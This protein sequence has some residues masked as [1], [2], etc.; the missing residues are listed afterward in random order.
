MYQ[1]YNMLMALTM[2]TGL[3]V[4]LCNGAAQMISE[5]LDP[6]MAYVKVEER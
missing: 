5:R 6:R 1:D 4:V 2:L 3:V